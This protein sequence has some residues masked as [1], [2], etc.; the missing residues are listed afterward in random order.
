MEQSFYLSGIVCVIMALVIMFRLM[1]YA[2]FY[3]P[4]YFFWIGA[5][6]A[7]TGLISLIHPLVFLF[8]MNRIIAVSVVLGGV[9]MAGISL[10]Y[11]VKTKHS[12]TI[13]QTIDDLMSGYAFN[14][15]HEVRIKASPEKVKQILQVTGVKDI[16]IARLLMKIRGIADEDVNL[17]DRA[18][19]N[20]VTSDTVS[21][22]DFNFF[23]V[24][25]DEWIT[26]MIL[27]SVIIKNKANQPAPPEI[28]ALEQFMLFN[29]P[30][31]VKVVVNFRFISTNNDETILTTE[32]RVQGIEKRDSQ[33]FGKSWRIIYQG[34]AIIRRVWLDTIKKKAQQV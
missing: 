1:H 20:L 22:P 21:T 29:D 6:L 11:P 13:N 24:A 34:S 14:E 27:K 31:Y 10:L 2:R 23:V 32:T 19:N 17:S 5:I 7:V 16:P 33:V 28:A 3:A 9:L 25:P 30:G 8:I 15:I 12:P 26:V 4:S 18:S